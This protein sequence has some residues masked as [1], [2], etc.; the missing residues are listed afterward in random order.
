MSNLVYHYCSIE[1]FTKI[2]EG[3][4]LKFSDIKKSNDDREIEL[5]WQ[6]YSEY[7]K[8][9]SNNANAKC[10]FDFF[11]NK[12]MDTTDFLVCCF[13]NNKDSLHLW[14]C[15]ADKGVAIGFNKEKL[16]E[17]SKTIAFFNNGIY[18]CKNNNNGFALC[19]DITYYEKNNIESFVEEQCKGIKLV[20]DKFN[21]IFYNAPFC[22]TNFWKEEQEWRIVIPI[23]YSEKADFSKVSDYIEEPNII[24]IKAAPDLQ[25]GFKSYCLI[26]FETS[27]IE[28]IVLAPNCKANV[29][30]IIK[31]LKA[32]GFY[33]TEDQ[34]IKSNGSLR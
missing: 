29:S 1:S 2:V 8:K 26:P 31:I 24:K 16:V 30:D 14:N 13:S 9:H 19:G 34:I 11:K 3:T 28:E 32:N 33:L 7:I 5:L 18:R 12:Q 4:S 15:Y 17:W 22:K 25:F 6:Y 21:V 10:S 23:I 27:A 20:V